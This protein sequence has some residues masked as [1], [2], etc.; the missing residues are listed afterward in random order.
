MF[1][2]KNGVKQG[3]IIFPVLFSV[4]M[5]GLFEMLRENGICCR[6]RNQD[7]GGLGYTND[8]TLMVPSHKGL[9]SLTHGCEDYTDEYDVVFNRSIYD[10]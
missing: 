4:Y 10:I 6:M 1:G 7:T 5:D 2:V 9:Q 8:L 3:G